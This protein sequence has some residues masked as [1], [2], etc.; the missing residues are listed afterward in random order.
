M[1]LRF[2]IISFALLTYSFAC[3]SPQKEKVNK[4][5]VYGSAGCSH[6]IKF[7]AKLDSVNL[8]YIFHD[9]D[10]SDEQALIMVDLVKKSGHTG[11]IK[12]PVVHINDEKLFVSPT[13]KKVIEYL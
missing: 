8:E 10:V 12:F 4:I 5:V 13:I 9:V 2:F 6:C 11:R 3:V 1:K 7:K